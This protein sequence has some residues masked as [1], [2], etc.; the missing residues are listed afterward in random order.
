MLNGGG[1]KKSTK[2]R[3]DFLN[4]LRENI[5]C[6][7]KASTE[8]IL[9]LF[10]DP[11]LVEVKN[12]RKCSENVIALE[13]EVDS[14]TEFGFDED[15]YIVYVDLRD[16]I[17]TMFRSIRTHLTSVGKNIFM[18]VID[19]EFDSNNTRIHR[20][21]FSSERMYNNVKKFLNYEELDDFLSEE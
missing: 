7:T 19:I 8:T 15:E 11:R 20:F 6:E 2:D 9:K 16:V 21:G 14:S 3:D 13:I 1:N 10:S 18:G 17:E 4:E 12:V 5:Y